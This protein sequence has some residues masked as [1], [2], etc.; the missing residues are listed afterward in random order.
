M[1]SCGVGIIDEQH[2]ALFQI[3]A[4]LQ[5]I[6][7]QFIDNAQRPNAMTE[8][9]AKLE[10]TEVLQYLVRYVN[11]HFITGKL[12]YWRIYFCDI[13]CDLHIS[14]NFTNSHIMLSFSH[15]LVR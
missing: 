7:D 4:N 6:S 13:V 10:V 15:S 1:F 9:G 8:E 14:A 3:A 5:F 12:F 2:C 11:R